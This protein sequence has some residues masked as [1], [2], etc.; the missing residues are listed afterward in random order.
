MS[1]GIDFESALVFFDCPRIDACGD[2]CPEC[3][4]AGELPVYIG[5][6]LANLSVAAGL[7]KAFRLGDD[8]G[9]SCCPCDAPEYDAEYLANQWIPG[10]GRPAPGWRES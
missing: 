3:D 7:A 5:T 9:Y 6:W 10:C 2:H 1:I 8:H 4:G